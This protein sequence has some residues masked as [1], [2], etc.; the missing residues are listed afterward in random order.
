MT[1]RAALTKALLDGK[2]LN[3]RNCLITVG[4]TNCSREI[5]RMI[6]KPFGVDVSR[7]HK[8][9]KSRYGQAVTWI[10]YKLEVNERNKEGIIKMRE[11]AI[12]EGFNFDTEN[13]EEIN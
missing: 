5:S 6:E 12:K 4:L 7:E 9:G 2:T 11:Y 3:V 13:G 8:E 1:A 10:N